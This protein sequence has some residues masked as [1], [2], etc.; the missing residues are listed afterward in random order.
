MKRRSET[1]ILFISQVLHNTILGCLKIAFR[2]RT[3]YMKIK[4]SI[5]LI[6]NWKRAI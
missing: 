2:A 4:D 3:T 5:S 6:T 1:S